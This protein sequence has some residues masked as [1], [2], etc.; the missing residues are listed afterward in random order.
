MFKIKSIKYKTL[1]AI[2]I[3]STITLLLSSITFYLFARHNMRNRLIN[4]IKLAADLTGE[5]M[6]IPLVFDDK[7]FGQ[8]TINY[9]ENIESIERASVFSADRVLF[10]TFN[11]DYAMKYPEESIFET[12]YYFEKG[13]GLHL[14]RELM[15]D[16]KVVGYINI[17]ANNNLLQNQAYAHFIFLFLLFILLSIFSYILARFYQRN[18]T[19]PIHN[20]IRHTNKIRES[21]NYTLH[22]RKKGT[23]EFNNLYDSFNHMISMVREHDKQQQ[24]YRIKIE[25]QNTKLT[26]SY[27]KLESVYK[28]LVKAKKK[29][30]ES[31][32]LKSAFLAN[33]SHEIRTPMNGILGFTNLLIEPNLNGEDRRRYIEIIHKSG[34]RLLN[35]VNDIIDISKIDTGQMDVS[36]TTLR[37]TDAIQ[38]SITF[39]MPE[40]DRKDLL[41]YSKLN[42]PGNHIELRTDATK[43]MSIINN[44]IKNAIKYTFKGFVEVG[45]YIE[46]HNMVFYVKDSGIGIPA[47]RQKAIFNR[48]EQADIYDKE[49]HE[50]SGL[51]LSI[52][53]SYAEMLKGKIWLESEIE[54]G[55]TFYFSHPYHKTESPD[56]INEI[57]NTNA[58]SALHSKFHF[59]IVEDEIV[60][61]EFLKIILEDYSL[62]ITHASN[63]R[64]AIEKYNDQIDIVLMDLKMPDINGY[65]AAQKILD[66]N[67]KAKIIAQTAF[68][69]K[70]EELKCMSNGF[71]G[72]ISKPIHKDHLFNVIHKIKN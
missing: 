37:L 24:Q 12:A 33:M 15:Q 34:K 56:E 65:E 64:S 58:T 3:V 68:A 25:K 49:A 28:E 21:K 35:T 54:K 43:F 8:Q 42:L 53:K 6:V 14:G 29:A 59:L 22:I 11:R 63:G 36:E 40:A 23:D 1:F 61:Y 9:L 5:N 57:E 62:S 72:F 18:L 50:G 7:I 41:L 2:L 70:S 71:S 27:N 31:D 69:S 17:L 45:C 67:P 48:F 51:G 30:E 66:T 38:E 47:D 32:D 55:S 46:D 52:A 10:C 4:E 26:E 19:N 60:S 16:G 20:L 13:N 44:L 39:F